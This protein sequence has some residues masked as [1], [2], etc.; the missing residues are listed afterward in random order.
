MDLSLFRTRSTTI[1]TTTTT[2]TTNNNNND[3]SINN[4]N[5]ININNTTTNGP[6]PLQDSLRDVRRVAHGPAPEDDVASSLFL[7][8]SSLLL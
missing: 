4:N 8:I 6:Q 2:T 5:D 7:S 1:T 3:S